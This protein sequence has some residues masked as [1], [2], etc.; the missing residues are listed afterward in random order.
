M[1]SDP[2]QSRIPLISPPILLYLVTEDWYFLSHRLP[3]AK[4][5][6][7]AGYDVHV[8]TRVGTCGATIE[9]HGFRLHPLRWPRGSLNPLAR[10]ALC[11]NVRALYRRLGPDLVHHVALE[12]TIIGSLAALR[13]PIVRLNAL[14]GLGFAFTSSTLKAR[15]TRAILGRL[16]AWLLNRPRSAALVQNADDRMAL[17][18]LGVRTERLFVIAGSGVDTDALTPLPEPAGPPTAAFVGRLLD[19]KGVRTLIAAHE[20][21]VRRGRVIQLYL[22]G[23]AD[24]AN[25]A[26]IS[27]DEIRNWARRAGISMLGQVKD[28]RDVWAVAHIAV[29]PSRR[30]GLPKSLLE[31]AACGRSIVATDVPGCRVIAQAGVNAL[32]VPPDDPAALAEAIDRLAQDRPLRQQFGAAGRALVENRFSSARIGRETVALYDKLLG[33]APA[34]LPAA[35]KPG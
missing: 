11:W 30:E 19:D 2:L 32:L 31:A 26:S 27:S 17:V 12:P 22:A 33:R 6:Q 3:M 14:A 28:I 20:L 16:L 35:S 7:A 9:G 25:P 23:E 1:R 5:A 13:L 8:A 24:P 29:L 15:T 10:A 4:A 18:H 34:P 21:L